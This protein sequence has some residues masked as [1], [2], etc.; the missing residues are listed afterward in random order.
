MAWF[1]RAEPVRRLTVIL[2][3]RRMPAMRG[4]AG[5]ERKALMDA[6]ISRPSREGSSKPGV[7][8]RVKRV[9]VVSKR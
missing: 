9:E 6:R 4:A 5:D 7:L 2:W 1:C 3:V 8:R